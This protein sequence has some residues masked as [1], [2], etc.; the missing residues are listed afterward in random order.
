MNGNNNNSG[1]WGSGGGNNPWGGGSSGKDFED[2]IKRAQ[3]FGNV[4]IDSVD[5]LKSNNYK[6][7]LI[8]LMQASIKRIS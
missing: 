4:A 7:C 6:E 8:N 3:H 2:T 5:V 1:P